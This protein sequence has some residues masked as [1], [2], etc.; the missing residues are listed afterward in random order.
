[1]LTHRDADDV[2]DDVTQVAMTSHR[3]YHDS[4]QFR[5]WTASHLSSHCRRISFSV[6]IGVA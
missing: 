3:Y 4:T 1:M 2:C 6:S 5:S